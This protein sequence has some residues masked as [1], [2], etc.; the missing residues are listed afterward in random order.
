M[1]KKIFTFLSLFGSLSTLFCCAL[2][3]VFVTIGA[4]AVFA[5]L[6]AAFP[7]IIWLVERKDALFLLTGLLLAFNF[8]FLKRAQNL[9]CPPNREQGELCDDSKKI[10]F[11]VYY[12]T[13]S[14]YA[15]GG[16]FSF[17]LPYL[18]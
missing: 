2:P 7:S 11:K 3:V 12:F 17:I 6:T 9:A 18:I 10:S 4:G 14:I 1:F 16:F 15:I 13:L 5:S 8:W